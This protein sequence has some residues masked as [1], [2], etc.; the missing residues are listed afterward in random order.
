MLLPI[1][2]G[3]IYTCIVCKN[4]KFSEK[5]MSTLVGTL[6]QVSIPDNHVLKKI[7]IKK[8]SSKNVCK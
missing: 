4:L 8:K 1:P 2:I 6:Y 3:Y 5:A 7:L